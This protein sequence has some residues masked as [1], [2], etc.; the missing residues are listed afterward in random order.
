MYANSTFK[1]VNESDLGHQ[2]YNSQ[3]ELEIGKSQMY[4][5]NKPEK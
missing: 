5:I 3:K 2:H 4:A 1:R